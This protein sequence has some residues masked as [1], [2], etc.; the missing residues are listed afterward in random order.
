M[1]IK[2]SNRVKTS[3]VFQLITRVRMTDRPTR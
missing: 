3:V 1:N 2:T